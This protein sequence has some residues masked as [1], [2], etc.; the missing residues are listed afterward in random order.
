MKKNNEKRRE[1]KTNR[2]RLVM[3][4]LFMYK[5]VVLDSNFLEIINIKDIQ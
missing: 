2:F 5:Y 4:I 3:I 1:K